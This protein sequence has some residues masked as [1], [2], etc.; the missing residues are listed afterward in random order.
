MPAALA[1]VER[2]GM[3]AFDFRPFWVV[4]PAALASRFDEQHSGRAAFISEKQTTRLIRSSELCHFDEIGRHAAP[5]CP[6]RR[7]DGSIS[8]PL[9][10]AA[11]FICAF[12]YCHSVHPQPQL[13]PSFI[14][15]HS[16][17]PR[18]LSAARC[19]NVVSVFHCCCWQRRRSPFITAVRRCCG[20]CYLILNRSISIR[21]VGS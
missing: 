6:V 15:G 2:L 21:K 20:Y 16:P 17:L 4:R 19:H 5:G 9:R 8:I 14:F 10:I 18:T 3:F 1:D 11:W 12:V 7:T 13:P